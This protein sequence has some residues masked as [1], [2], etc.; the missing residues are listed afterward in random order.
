MYPFPKFIYLG[1][2]VLHPG[3]NGSNSEQTN[4]I[5]FLGCYNDDIVWF[6]GSTGMFN[7]DGL[8]HLE[9]CFSFEYKT[10]L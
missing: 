1:S 3:L 8:Y 5:S 4:K 2:Q 10:R 9:Y 7:L 6:A